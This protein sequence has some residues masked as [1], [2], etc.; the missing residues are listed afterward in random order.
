MFLPRYNWNIIESGVKHHQLFI[1][2]LNYLIV[3]YIQQHLKVIHKTHSYYK[4][5]INNTSLCKYTCIHKTQQKFSLDTK[6]HTQYSTKWT[7]A[8]TFLIIMTVK[9]HNNLFLALYSETCL[10]RTL[11]KPKTCLN[12]TN[13]S[14]P[15]GFCFRQ[16][17]L[18]L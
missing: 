5:V 11:S 8:K 2:F 6:K 17:L 12:W 13:Y 14:V 4:Q 9:A 3:C 10:N 15:K 7:Q 18:Y 16:V 1:C